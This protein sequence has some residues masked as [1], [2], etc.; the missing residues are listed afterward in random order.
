[1]ADPV[2]EFERYRAELLAAL[3]NDD[4]V[5]VLRDN[6]QAIEQLTASATAEE[7]GTRP[8]PGE[9]SPAEV[10]S[11]LADSDLVT[12]VRVRMIVT[13]DRP[14]LIGY[15]QD[16]WTARFARLDSSPGQTL[17]RW[18]ALR[19]ANVQLYESLSESEW[20]RV[21]IHSERGE[22]SARLVVRLLAGHDRV[23]MDQFRRALESAQARKAATA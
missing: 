4:P 3:G 7:L 18:Q 1:M 23:H 17:E 19:R 5:A 9:W 16:A 2:T 12:A 11:H 15:D 13:Q 20:Q 10:L 21:G 14:S 8:A 22:E 6:L